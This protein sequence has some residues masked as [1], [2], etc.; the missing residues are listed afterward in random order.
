MGQTIFAL[1]MFGAPPD[2]YGVLVSN[3]KMQK[4][5]LI[6]NPWFEDLIGSIMFNNYT[7]NLNSVPGNRVF[8]YT[9]TN[10]LATFDRLQFYFYHKQNLTYYSK[11]LLSNVNTISLDRGS[12]T[13]KMIENCE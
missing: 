12:L 6:T 8:F 4:I 11:I 2:G 3:V 5:M 7:S 13:Q 10:F 9:L 1:Q